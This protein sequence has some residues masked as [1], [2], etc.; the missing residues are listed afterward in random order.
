MN[1][2]VGQGVNLF[3]KERRRQS[4]LPLLDQFIHDQPTECVNLSTRCGLFE[5]ILQHRQIA[6]AIIVIARLIWEILGALWSGAIP[7]KPAAQKPADAQLSAP[8]QRD[9]GRFLERS[10]CL[11]CCVGIRGQ[12]LPHQGTT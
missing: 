7:E 9:V 2:A 8:L 10:L 12:R 5:T 1:C 4:F 6:W 11:Y 3:A